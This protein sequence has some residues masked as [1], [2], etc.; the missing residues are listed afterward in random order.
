LQ[1]PPSGIQQVPLTQLSPIEQEL[2]Q[3]PQYLVVFKSVHF[4]LQQPWP[5]L[6][7]V[8]QFPQ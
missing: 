5:E 1:G 7:C 4:P 3:L 2:V 8:L 6:H